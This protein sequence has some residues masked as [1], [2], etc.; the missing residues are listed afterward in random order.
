MKKKERKN[1]IHKIELVIVITMLAFLSLTFIRP[2]ITGHVEAVNITIYKQDMD[3]VIDRDSRYVF[4]S[5]D[6]TP[7]SLTQ[8][9]L[10]GEVIGDGR[11]EVTIN[12]GEKQLL[13]YSNIA[14]KKGRGFITGMAVDDN[15]ESNE[16]KAFLIIEESEEPVGEYQFI[17]LG[18]NQEVISGAFS[19]A[20]IETCKIPAGYFNS[21]SYQLFFKIEDNITLKLDELIF[22]KE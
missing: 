4:S 13:I 18:K 10:S 8:I 2:K 5:P 1:I 12:D 14:E 7:L 22:R 15:A 3:L 19:Y 6:N 21:S 11:V 9:K 20:C 17:P 16:E